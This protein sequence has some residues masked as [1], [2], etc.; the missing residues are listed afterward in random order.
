VN[1]EFW[2]TQFREWLMARHYSP[3]T[4]AN[5]TGELRPFCEWLEAA[6]VTGVASIRKA[7]LEGYRGFLYE[8][9]WR[10]QRLSASTQSYRLSALKCFVQFLYEDDY[11]PSNLG[12]E[13]ALPRTRRPLPVSVLSEP[14][15][16]RL[17]ESPDVSTPRGLRHRAMLE[18]FYGTA[19]RNSELRQL[20]LDQVDLPNR[21]LRLVGKGGRARVLPLGETAAHWLGMYLVRGRPRTGRDNRLVFMTVHGQAWDRGRVAEVVR[22]AARAAGIQKRV[23]PHLLRAT[24][25]THMLRHGAGLRSLQELLGHASLDTTQRYARLEVS[26][27]RRTVERCHPRERRLR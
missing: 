10:G 21:E 25:V 1:P 13:L 6:G 9:T 3:R 27:L 4:V 20:T 26:D 24:C 19:I 23:T 12:A 2:Q 8:A 5:Y 14:Q 11:L 22:R 17:L 15:A 16:K 7:H 18:L